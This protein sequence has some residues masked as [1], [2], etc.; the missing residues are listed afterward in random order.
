MAAN[1]YALQRLRKLIGTAASLSDPKAYEMLKCLS[2]AERDPLCESPWVNDKQSTIDDDEFNQE[3]RLIHA[4]NG[5]K[6]YDRRMLGAKA[7]QN[8][9]S[10]EQE[11]AG[12]AHRAQAQKDAEG[13]MSCP[14][15]IC[16][17][18]VHGP[19]GSR[20]NESS[21]RNGSTTT[22]KMRMLKPR[23]QTRLILNGFS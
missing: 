17:H 16:A 20:I 10:E 21:G 4:K 23:K 9:E 7:A 13:R 3:Q 11:G 1:Y 12:A 6:A 5:S 8:W 18:R 15:G 22:M 14:S 19:F 2:A